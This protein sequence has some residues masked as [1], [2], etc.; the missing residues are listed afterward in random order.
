M[1]WYSR[2]LKNYS[3]FV[4]LHTVK[5]SG[6]INKAEVDFGGDFLIFSMIQQIL[7]I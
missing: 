2:V 4:V 3:Q 1:V 7:A 5:G 6:I